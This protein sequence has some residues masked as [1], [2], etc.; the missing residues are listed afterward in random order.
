VVRWVAW[1][2]L[3]S[4]ALFLVAALFTSETYRRWQRRRRI[5]ELLDRY[6]STVDFDEGAGRS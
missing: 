5:A 1:G 2:L 4:A 3:A 6:A